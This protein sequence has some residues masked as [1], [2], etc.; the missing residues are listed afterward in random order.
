MVE[1]T[2]RCGLRVGLALLA[3]ALAAGADAQQSTI[4]LQCPNDTNGDGFVSPAEQA[5]ADPNVVC[6]HFSA[7]DGFVRMAD[8]KTLYTFGFG[9]IPL[10][11]G[12]PNEVMD[13]GTLAANFPAPTLTAKQGDDVYLTITNV[14]MVMRPDL[15]DPHSVHWHG[16]PQ[17]AAVFDGVPESSIVVNMGASFSYYYRINDPGTYMY[18]CHVEATE[19]MQMGMLG[20]LFVRPAQDGT[21]LGGFT[22][23]A[24]NDGD[25]STGYDVE[26]PIQMSSFDP[27]F[28]DASFTVQPLPFADMK[29]TYYMLNGRGYPQTARALPLPPPTV[30]PTGEPFDQPAKVSQ[31][32]SSLIT[33]SAGQ[34]ILLRISNLSVTDYGTLATFGI[35]MK[36]VG[37]DARRLVGGDGT[38]QYYTTNSVT[39]GGGETADVILDTTG[40]AP[41]TY[42]LYTTNL[43]RLANAA[44]NF[45]GQMTHIVIN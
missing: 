22:S 7:G 17:A 12:D 4:R 3:L 34:R 38:P 28:H 6:R 1:R 40:V 31:P 2:T 18:H 25:G 8:G 44:E 29:D 39:L 30:D 13:L 14:G 23:F 42:F 45:G 21:S 41:G 15:S 27:V 32:V 33:A 35:P 19:H 37:R 16:F 43:H 24:Y 10:S 26:Y 9:E 11:V 36:V 5:A 20:N